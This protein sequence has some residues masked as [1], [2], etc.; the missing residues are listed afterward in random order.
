MLPENAFV[1]L[2]E[3]C[4]GFKVFVA[5][6]DVR[7]PLTVV[8]V[9]VEIEHRSNCVNPQTVNVVFVNPEHCA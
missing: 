3:E 5:A 8:S 7:N 2:F 1:E 9:I 4:N 6:V